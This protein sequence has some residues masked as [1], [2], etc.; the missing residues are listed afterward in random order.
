MLLL[1]LVQA[2]DAAV[3]ALTGYYAKSFPEGADVLDICSS[4]VSH[5]PPSW[6]HGKRV[7][8]GEY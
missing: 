3:K 1:V 4:W 8:L 7:G 5:F 6:K 2:D